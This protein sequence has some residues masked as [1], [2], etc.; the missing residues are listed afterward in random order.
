MILKISTIGYWR[1][2]SLESITT[3]E[4][5]IRGQSGS[6]RM[7]SWLLLE[8]IL[9]SGTLLE[10]ASDSWSLIDRTLRKLLWLQHGSKICMLLTRIREEQMR[11]LLMMKAMLELDSRFKNKKKKNFPVTMIMKP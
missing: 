2:L 9:L 7:Q 10:S 8:L 6:V 4:T 5:K 1:K 11:V 3:E